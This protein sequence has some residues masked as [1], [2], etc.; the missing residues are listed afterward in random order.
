[1]FHH[2]YLCSEWQLEDLV[3]LLTIV[4]LKPCSWLAWLD[5]DVYFVLEQWILSGFDGYFFEAFYRASL[6][7]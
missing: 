7:K 6:L 5:Y 4:T 2:L 3:E 1:M